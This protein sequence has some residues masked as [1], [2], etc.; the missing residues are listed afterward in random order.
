M[1][2]LGFKPDYERL[3]WLGRSG[4]PPNLSANPIYNSFF[5]GGLATSTASAV[6][7]PTAAKPA[8]A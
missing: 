5:T 1:R 7:A 4:F 3:A 8:S 2:W 6:S